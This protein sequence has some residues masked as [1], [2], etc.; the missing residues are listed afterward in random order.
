M[1]N[2]VILMPP[3]KG[4]QRAT[5][6]LSQPVFQPPETWQQN[7]SD[8]T[9]FVRVDKALAISVRQKQPM[10]MLVAMNLAENQAVAHSFEKAPE[11]F[12]FA[13]LIFAAISYDSEIKPA[14][15]DDPS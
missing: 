1:S 12:A 10:V 9:E 4:L 3:K 11:A 13:D 7:P 14:E 6:P 5:P 15:E 8:P 2:K